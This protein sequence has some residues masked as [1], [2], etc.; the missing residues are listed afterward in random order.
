MRVKNEKKDSENNVRKQQYSQTFE[1][2]DVSDSAVTT[3][4][5]DTS[6]EHA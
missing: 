6:T 1:K 2:S 5:F 3:T 4:S